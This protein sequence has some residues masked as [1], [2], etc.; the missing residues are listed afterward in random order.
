MKACW[1][2]FTCL[3]DCFRFISWSDVQPEIVVNPFYIPN[4]FTPNADGINDNFF[5]SNYAL[6]VKSY[7]LSVFN[8]W[9][10]KVFIG[11]DFND[12]W[13]G[14]TFNGDE[15][16]QGVYVYVIEVVTKGGKDHRFDGTI[17]LIR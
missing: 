6:D 13:N 1:K 14:K 2:D 12:F 7:K 10:Q 3:S 9:G 11:S 15:A 8:R 16:P 5:D 17:N 4:A